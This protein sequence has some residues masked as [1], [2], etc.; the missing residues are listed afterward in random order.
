MILMQLAEPEGFKQSEEA[1]SGATMQV[2][3][4]PFVNVLAHLANAGVS[5]PI[6]H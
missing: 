6:L 4:L 2:V 3:E 1:V 5:V